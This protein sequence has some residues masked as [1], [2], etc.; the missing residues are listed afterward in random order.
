MTF[1]NPLPL[2]ILAAL[3]AAAAVV[4]WLAYRR[5]PIASA[6]RLALS[7]LR[8]VIGE[9]D[10]DHTLASRDVINTKIRASMDQSTDRWGVKVTRVELKEIVP[11]QEI[12]I[13][14][15]KQM[16][17]ERSRRAI[18][19]EAEGAKQSAV[20][21]AEGRKQ[22]AIINAEGQRESAILEADG[23]AQALYRRAAGEAQAMGL[24]G[25]V[26]DIGSLRERVVDG[27]TGTV[28]RDETAFADAAIRLLGNDALWLRQHAAALAR[29][30]GFGWQEA[31]AEFEKLL[32]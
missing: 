16:T 11:P 25:V 6:R 12:R 31:A 5:V 23:A 32:P 15:E 28:A 14:M 22:A 3:V 9:L 10:L 8:N 26:Q 1:A 27:V 18:V 21:N 24:P 7:A 4:A 29:Q 19:T 30:R 13:T 17:A 20:L 2:W